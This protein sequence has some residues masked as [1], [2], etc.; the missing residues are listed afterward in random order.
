V[1]VA[2]ASGSCWVISCLA[3]AALASVAGD[4][5]VDSGI[6]DGQTGAARYRRVIIQ[7]DQHLRLVEEAGRGD[8]AADRDVQ[9]AP[10]VRRHRYR[11]ANMCAKLVQQRGVH[12]DAVVTKDGREAAIGWCAEQRRTGDRECR[13]IDSADGEELRRPA[14]VIRLTADRRHRGIGGKC[15]LILQVVEDA[16]LLRREGCDIAAH[17]DVTAIPLAHVGR[18]RVVDHAA[19]QLQRDDGQH[20]NRDAKDCEQRALA[21]A[22]QGP[23]RVRPV[24]SD[25]HRSYPLSICR[26]VLRAESCDYTLAWL[27]RARRSHSGS[28]AASIHT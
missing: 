24:H 21:A 3:V 19:D 11:V 1:V 12:D 10:V 6:R 8:D 17:G 23:R 2:V 20:A 5:G 9:R 22:R 18:Q 25:L 4:V 15:A 7:R 13:G 14:L 28:G 26:P 16:Q 27:T